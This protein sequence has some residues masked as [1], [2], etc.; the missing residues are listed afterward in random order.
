[1]T[2]LFNKDL[3]CLY[4]LLD[5]ESKQRIEERRLQYPLATKEH[6]DDLKSNHWVTD[7]KYG[8]VCFIAD[9]FTGGKYNPTSVYALFRG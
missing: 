4:E 7:L 8:T 9:L 5:E 6:I 1:M 3:I 2:N